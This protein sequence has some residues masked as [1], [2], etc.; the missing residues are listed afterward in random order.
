VTIAAMFPGGARFAFTIMDD[1]DN[2]T[3]ANVQPVY[4]L[5]ES[6]GMFVTKTVWTV[7]CEEGSE[8]FG[9]AQTLDDPDY[10]DFVVDLNRRGFEIAFHGAT[11]ESSTRDRTTRALTRF[12]EL[13][14]PPKVHANHSVNRENL[15]W[16]IDRIDN[17][18]LRAAYGA[19]LGHADDFYQGHVPDSPFWWGDLCAAEITYVRN[20]SFEEVNLRRVNP[21]MPYTDERRPYAPWWFSASDAEN[22]DAFVDLM[23]VKNQTRLESEGG[24]CI[25][26]THLGKGFCVTGEVRQDV[27]KLLVELAARRGWFVPVGPMLDELRRRRTGGSLPPGEW[28]RMQWQWARD[29]LL[30]RLAVRRRER[31]RKTAQA[32]RRVGSQM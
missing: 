21:S 29:L 17:P 5:L 26:A 24:V 19:V 9:A 13:F 3:V 20:L 30:R 6:L 7:R 23:S 28:R 4:R 8:V 14:G 25:V 10:L 18:L 1:T 16:G 22:V 15:Y 32:V 11:M 31:Q 12:T 27:R 2:A